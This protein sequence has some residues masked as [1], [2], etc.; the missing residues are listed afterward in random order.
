MSLL[1]NYGPDRW[2][3]MEE[4]ARRVTD[5]MQRAMRFMDACKEH[6]LI[7]EGMPLTAQAIHDQ[8]HTYGEMWDEFGAILHQRHMIQEFPPTPQLD[9]SPD[10]QRAFEIILACMDEI[11]KALLDFIE[12][13][14]QARELRPLARSA[15]NLQMKNSQD[16]T[17]WLEAAKMWEDEPRKLSY[18]K[19]ILALFRGDPEAEG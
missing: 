19:W 11:D 1:D 13:A 5:A 15:E 3:A 4:P 2:P 14:E 6:V 12:A 17:K 8:A 16:Y 18:D 7:L 10:L 9:E